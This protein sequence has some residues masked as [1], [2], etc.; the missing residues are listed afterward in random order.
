MAVTSALGG[1]GSLGTLFVSIA[2]DASS[3][4]SAMGQAT[5]AV[6]QGGQG[7]Q[8][9]LSLQEKAFIAMA[10]VAVGA[11][12]EIGRHSIEEYAKFNKAMTESTAIMENM[13]A[14]TRQGLEDTARSLA[15]DGIIPATKLAEG[16]F[17]LSSAG[18]S[19]AQS[20]AALGPVMKFAQA[21]TIDMAKATELLMD[22]QTDLG[23]RMKDPIQN[24]ENLIRV[25]DILTKVNNIASGTTQ[26]FAEALTTKA[27]AAMRNANISME[28]GVAVLA[29][30]AN[31]GL[32]GAHAGEAFNIVIRDM[33]RAALE[34]SEAFRRYNISVFDSQGNMRKVADII[35]DMEK[36]FSGMSAE[37]KRAT[38]EM[39]G[40]QD[41]SLSYTLSLIGTSGAI[42]DFEKTLKGAGGT[43]ED[44]SEKQLKS[45][46]SQLTI[47]WNRI[48]DIAITIGEIL[49]PNL[50]ILNKMLQ[51]VT[52]SA[53]EWKG[54][55]KD[56][57]DFA[58]PAILT[59]I[60]MV[61]DAINGWKMIIKSGEVLFLA[62]ATG[63]VS[64]Y[65]LLAQA[66][67][68]VM[69][70]IVN[71]VIG[72]V[73]LSIAGV[74]KLLPAAHQI[75]QLKI[76]LHVDTSGLSDMSQA[77]E[78]S[79][80]EA[81]S[82]LD[83][84]V[85]KGKF[86]DRVVAGFQKAATSVAT[87]VKKTTDVAV[88]A[89][90]QATKQIDVDMQVMEHNSTRI[91]SLLDKM[92][93][94]DKKDFATGKRVGLTQT[95]MNL[96]VGGF[97]PTSTQILQ[98]KKEQDAAKERFKILQDSQNKE[99]AL[100]AET[101]KRK[102]QAV[103]LYNRQV[104][105]LHLAQSQIILN[106]SS[107]IFDS[108]ATMAESWGGKQ[109][110]LYKGMFAASKAFAIAESIV[111][112]Q[113]GIA[114]ASAIPWPANIAAIAS[115]VA[116]TASIVTNISS[117]QMAISGAKARGGGVQA[118]NAFLIGEEGPEIFVPNEGGNIIPH[119]KIGMGRGQAPKVVINNYT[120]AQP[121][122]T[123]KDDGSGR[124]VEVMLKKF[125]NEISS[126]IRDGRGQIPK[127][128]SQT[129]GLRRGVTK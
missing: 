126:E 82:E 7:M 22:S 70:G 30:Y 74:N 67:A 47:T 90:H 15:K 110:A 102:L 56:I 104:K 49:A 127:A 107:Q 99:V 120:D 108:L 36:A 116:A 50:L 84:L 66:I 81:L 101:Q 26:E 118:G 60:G 121:V 46:V 4:I 48:K 111:K 37:Q 23:L 93:A 3:L 89:F 123:E 12:E 61:G 29:A 87:G 96:A 106:S 20:Q 77:L 27:G 44:V 72:A 53:D 25:G 39:L 19:V 115:V 11:L 105:Q 52:E 109:S 21:S 42:R 13:S 24:M 117:T 62:F 45:F 58:L 113:Q 31:Q 57:S 129:F 125:R 103:E 28:E 34:N 18:L 92:G 94:P 14:R 86:S 119:D 35:G 91:N 78:E 2:A 16:Y 55:L 9:S 128:L 10:T 64:S 69:E 76:K 88:E 83:E 98:N 68:F 43:T 79:R 80:K 65:T 75:N 41:R 38:F 97:D 8:R 1:A 100:N 17:H 71:S 33:Q 54:T 40:F 124:V 5:S 6:Q 95:E 63:M 59:A 122:V 114:A 51:Q 73:N 85:G 112:I 32:K